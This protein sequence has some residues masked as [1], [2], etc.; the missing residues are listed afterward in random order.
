VLANILEE[1]SNRQVKSILLAD[2]FAN[3]IFIA[4]LQYTYL[5]IIEDF[6]DVQ[7]SHY[8]LKLYE[9]LVFLEKELGE[10]M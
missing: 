8:F 9:Q 7:F 5:N 2:I 1:V 4:L 10:D 6:N 3:F